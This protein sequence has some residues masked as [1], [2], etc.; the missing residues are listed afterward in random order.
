MA[1]RAAAPAGGALV[2]T[3]ASGVGEAAEGGSMRGGSK[4]T[5]A[6][7]LI[8][9]ARAM[10]GGRRGTMLKRANTSSGS[11]GGGNG[12]P[13]STPPSSNRRTTGNLPGVSASKVLKRVE[14]ADNAGSSSC[15]APAPAASYDGLLKA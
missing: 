13:D 9:G 3:L 6:Q 7:K 14:L 11:L 12:S 5:R 2:G 1:G 4:A 10:V 8:T 15:G